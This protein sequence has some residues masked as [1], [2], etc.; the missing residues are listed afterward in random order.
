[1]EGAMSQTISIRLTEELAQ[2]LAKLCCELDRSKTFVIKK[3]LENYIREY[4]D[5]QIA[6]D[7]LKDK[8]D[9]TLSPQALRKSLGL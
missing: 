6:L 2:P 4:A 8:D 7:R 9:K 5:Y 3:A 1:M